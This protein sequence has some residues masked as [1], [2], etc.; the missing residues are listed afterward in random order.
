MGACAVVL[1]VYWEAN[2][3][4]SSCPCQEVSWHLPH[5]QLPL[6]TVLYLTRPTCW[7]LLLLAVILK[8][9]CLLVSVLH[10]SEGLESWSVS[11]QPLSRPLETVLS[12]V[13]ALL[14]TSTVVCTVVRQESLSQLHLL[15]LG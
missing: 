14:K 5:P 3:L 11:G 15:V 7:L 1:N 4:S 6:V 12:P 8:Y 2:G 9:S 10:T 13:A